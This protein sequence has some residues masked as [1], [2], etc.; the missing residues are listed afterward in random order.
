M[1]ARRQLSVEDW[2]GIIRRRAWLFVI[3]ALLCAAGGILVSLALPKQYTS[4]TRVLVESPIVPDDYVKPVVSDDLNR[5]LASMQGEILSR[6]H[7]QELVT[8]F[9]LYQEDT[10]RVPMEVL[11][12]RLRKA[13]NVA[14]LSPTPGTNSQAVLGFNVDVTL[15]QPKLAQDVCTEIASMFM[16]QNLRLR[17]E[18]AEDTT[19]FLSKQLNDAKQKLDE[20][21]AKLAAF[22]NQYLGAQPEDEQTNLTVLAGL[23]PQLEAVTQSLNEVQ[24]NKAFAES[25]LNQQLTGLKASDGT[26]PESQEQELGQLQTQL[27]A[28]RAR[29]TDKHPE[30]LKLQA[31]IADLEK[32]MQNPQ[33]VTSVPVK[34]PS[35]PEPLEIQQLR[36]QV[37]QAD[38][39]V[40]EKR[41]EQAQLQQQIKT[42]QGRIQLTPMV[43]EQYKS[44]TRDYQT[45]LDFYNDLLKKR[46]D[47]Q[48][49]TELERRQEGENFRVLDPPSYPE[50]PSFPDRRL[51]ALGGLAVGLALG[52]GLVKLAELRD[53]SLRGVR[54]VEALLGV[55]TL[56]VITSGNLGRSARVAG[57]SFFG[58]GSAGSSSLSAR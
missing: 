34:Q 13:I 54:D 2:P 41:Q 21:D 29:Y 56:A 12:D 16:D 28:L 32:R 20:Q 17:E 23:T 39:T 36:A 24:E 57:T 5:R 7:L 33:P 1:A 25:M 49:A 53:K 43:Q 46:D 3:P 9:H 50:R 40:T 30:V 11:V 47:A 14:P 37:H 31:E 55:P 27:S 45:A 42:L 52:A 22:Q 38:L 44:L 18:Q 4:H 58:T 15:N 10:N 35:G 48:M 6:T 26:S 8:K 51:F 19:Q